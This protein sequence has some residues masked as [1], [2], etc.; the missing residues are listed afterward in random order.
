MK[1]LF[2][3]ALLISSG[4]AIA[5]PLPDELTGIWTT[6]SS[7]FRGNLLWKGEA[8]YLDSD[9]VGA[10][11]A[12]DGSDVLGGRIVVLAYDQ[13]T[14]VGTIQWTEYGKGGPT[15]DFRYEP[16]THTLIFKR[17][18][19]TYQRRKGGPLTSELRKGLVLED[20][21]PPSQ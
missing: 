1:I 9:G 8:L 11:L 20:K 17:N 13:L 19:K 10:E 3:L 18:G 14:H 4:S 15:G 16:S 5:I 21:S 7:E 2:S 6:P 12:G